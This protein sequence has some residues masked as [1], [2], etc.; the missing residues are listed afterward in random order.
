VTVGGEIRPRIFSLEPV[1]GDWDHWISM[2]SRLSVDA[3]FQE[4]L[5]LFVQVQ[6][7]RL[8][9]EEVTNRDRSADA[10]DFHQAYLEVED[11]PWVDGLLRAGRQE[12]SLGEGRFIAA[13]DWGQAGQTFDGA[14]WIRPSGEGRLDLVYL[15]LQEGSAPAHEVSADL[16]AA[17]AV[18]PAGALGSLEVLAIHDRSTGPSKNRQNTVGPLWKKAFGDLSFRVQGMAQLGQRGGEDVSA[19][20]VAARST[21]EVLDDR[22]SVTLWYDHLSGD[23]DPYDATNR[24]FS[25]LFGARHRYY[26]RADYFLDIPRDTGG[27]GLRDAALK[28]SFSPG[29]FLSANLDLHTFRTAERVFLSSR[30]LAEEADLWVRYRFRGALTLEAGYS[31][32]WAGTAMEEMGRLEGTGNMAYFMSSMRF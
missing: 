13:P 17:W 18:V 5:R 12:V 16:L 20:M 30:H 8:W 21:L 1:V 15:R 10:V 11:V 29:P 28:L 14:R 6:D 26:G 4:G 7:V 22:G 19:F 9:G 25:T 3:R 31:L 2:R 23:D 32:V 24:A 27:L